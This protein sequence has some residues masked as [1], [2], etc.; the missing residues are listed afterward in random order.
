MDN[1]RKRLIGRKHRQIT[2]LDFLAIIEFPFWPDLRSFQQSREHYIHQELSDISNLLC[3]DCPFISTVA[4]PWRRDMVLYFSGISKGKPSTMSSCT[5][6]KCNV[7]G[8]FELQ[9]QWEGINEK[10]CFTTVLIIIQRQSQFCSVAFGSY[11]TGSE[12]ERR[13]AVELGATWTELSRLRRRR[14]G[15]GHARP[16]SSDP[17][18]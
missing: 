12:E 9:S 10:R 11:R 17:G 5:P 7:P 15:R 18:T 16:G 6:H 1:A 2:S 13:E 8:R 4:L 3:W 14:R